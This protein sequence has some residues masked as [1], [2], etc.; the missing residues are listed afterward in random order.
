MNDYAFIQNMILS[1][2]IIAIQ[3]NQL[4]LFITIW[5]N[6]IIFKYTNK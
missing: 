2:M 3:L 5:N 4:S 1:Y 6:P